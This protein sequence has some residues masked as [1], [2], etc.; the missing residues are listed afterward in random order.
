MSRLRQA[1]L[2]GDAS[3]LATM[4]RFPIKVVVDG[5]RVM[6]NNAQELQ[7]NYDKIFIGAFV[8]GIRQSPPCHM[9][10][11]DQ[12]VMLGNGQVWV[13]PVNKKPAV[14]AINNDVEKG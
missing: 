6:I 4:V 3:R 5:K 9:F 13:A 11:R 2:D 7:R 12:G 14:I 8:K 1:I 10:A